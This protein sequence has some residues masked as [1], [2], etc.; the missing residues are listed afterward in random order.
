VPQA[1]PRLFRSCGWSL[2]SPWCRH[3][4]LA[5]AARPMTSHIGG[6]STG[7][8]ERA[9][10]IRIPSPTIARASGTSTAGIGGASFW[11]TMTTVTTAIQEAL[12]GPSATNTSIMPMLERT[13]IGEAGGG[14]H[15]GCLARGRRHHPDAALR[16]ETPR[17]GSVA[18][19]RLRATS[20]S[21]RERQPQHHL[22]DPC[23]PPSGDLPDRG[24]LR[25]RQRRHLGHP[26][27]NPTRNN[28]DIDGR[29]RPQRRLPRR[30]KKA[31]AV[32]VGAGAA[33]LLIRRTNA[34][35]E[36]TGQAGCQR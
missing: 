23:R 5:R 17:I 21:R 28:H 19:R 6:L 16:Q 34:R 2:L 4:G 33:T 10:T 13:Q 31:R 32:V 27:S 36:G 22:H 26:R 29:P 14:S 7:T 11:A 9:S 3:N 24:A 8:D 25:W 1:I 18:A 20:S 15:Q 30:P 12:M 35:S